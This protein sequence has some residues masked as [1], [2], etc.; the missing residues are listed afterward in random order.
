MELSYQVKDLESIPEVLREAYKPAS[1]GGGFV[2][3]VK[4]GVVPESDVVGL[5]TKN[6]E[7]LSKLKSQAEQYNSL[8]ENQR[9][10]ESER[11]EWK[12]KAE[13][14]EK[15]YLP[16]EELAKKEALAAKRA[17]EEEAA[18]T[19]AAMKRG[20][21]FESLFTSRTI[22][23]DIVSAAQR[24]GAAFPQQI[25]DMLSGKSRLDW[26]TDE[27]GKQTDEHVTMIEVFVTE[28]DSRVKKWLPADKAVETILSLPE[29]KNLIDSKFRA[30]GG[31]TG[32]RTSQGG[33]INSM[34][35]TQMITA[36][37]RQGDLR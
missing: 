10:T 24:H 8:A 21:K 13:A 17:R 4:G 29:N 20:D 36:G 27:E 2:L 23:S 32:G 5:K 15:Q 28:G 19:D 33:D 25:E 22:K 14:L 6:G 12:L 35:T 1:D 3:A 16:P 9:L 30:G 31:A 18:K 7:L 37:I 11:S 34:T 26:V